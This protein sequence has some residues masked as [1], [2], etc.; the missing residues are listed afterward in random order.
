[1]TLEEGG[2]E[3][4]KNSDREGGGRGEA[5]LERDGTL[6]SLISGRRDVSCS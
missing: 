2:R 4:R 1:M 5:L 3:G 6:P